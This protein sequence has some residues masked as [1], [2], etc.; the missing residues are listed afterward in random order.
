MNTCPHYSC[1]HTALAG[2]RETIVQVRI[3]LKLLSA[4]LPRLSAC[5]A[6]PVFFGHL[7]EWTSPGM[8]TSPLLH[9]LKSY[10]T[11][12]EIMKFSL[13]LSPHKSHD[14]KKLVFPHIELVS[15]SERQCETLA[16][17]LLS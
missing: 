2:H 11:F 13:F 4:A 3:T 6:G 7:P 1:V 10:F 12:R 16:Q 14:V 15:G 9:G 5:S 8:A 17:D